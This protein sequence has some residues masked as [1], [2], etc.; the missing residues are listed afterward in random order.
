MEECNW[1]KINFKIS[2]ICPY[3]VKI[4]SLPQAPCWINGHFDQ[5]QTMFGFFKILIYYIPGYW[6]ACLKGCGIKVIH[7]LFNEI[8]VQ[9][10]LP[11][12]WKRSIII[13]LHK[14]KDKLDCS[15]Y[16][17]ISLLCHCNKL[18]LSIILRRVCSKTEDILSEAQCGFRNGSTIDQIF[19]LR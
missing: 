3:L 14:K 4:V 17:G 5:F 19:I 9:E 12:D 2:K 18:F 8:W 6:K 1:N 15:N 10:K 13:P 16:R 7:K 11:T